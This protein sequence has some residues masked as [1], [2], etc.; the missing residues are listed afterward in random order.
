MM[1][2]K[3]EINMLN[4]VVLIGR[5]TQDLEVKILEDGRKVTDLILAVQ[6]PFKNIDGQYDADFIKCSVWEGLSNI[7]EPY[8]QK[9]TMIALKGRIQSYKRE[10]DTKHMT[11]LEVVAERISYLK[12]TKEKAEFEN[13]TT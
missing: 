7:I 3:K 6:R 4:Q 1:E 13:I 9:G 5:L 12:D 11:M 8:C 10:I 2:E